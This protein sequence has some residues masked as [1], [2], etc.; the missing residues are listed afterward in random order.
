ML[1]HQKSYQ[2]FM[3]AMKLLHVPV[4]TPSIKT[5]IQNTPSIKTDIQT[6]GQSTAPTTGNYDVFAKQ[7]AFSCFSVNLKRD[8]SM[9]NKNNKKFQ[10]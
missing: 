3:A 10:S 6:T 5:D 1:D 8:A 7:I 2:R 9:E 4:D